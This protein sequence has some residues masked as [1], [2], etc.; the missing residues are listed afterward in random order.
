M[1]DFSLPMLERLL[2][3]FK[4]N[5]YQIMR[6]D[7][8]WKNKDYYNSFDRMVLLRHDVDRFPKMAVT[9]AEMEAGNGIFGTFFFRVKP[10]VFKENIIKRIVSLGHEIGYHYEVMTDANGSL[11]E[12]DCLFKENLKRLRDIFPIVSAS[13][14]SRP[15]S[16]FD[17][18]SFWDHVSLEKYGLLGETYRNIDHYKFMYLAD[19]GRNW[20]SDRNVVW[21]YVKGS[22]LSR[23][24]GTPQLCKMIES[25]EINKIHLLIHPNRWR[26]TIVGWHMEYMTDILINTTKSIIKKF[27][28]RELSNG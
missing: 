4:N 24:S 21:D 15:L 14:H 28:T 5:G 25:Q 12:A 22:A 26:S 11:R 9:V 8:Y 2:L 20:S 3:T 10:R 18:R 13:M 19:S 17:N 6:F 27:R 1:L 23:I 16:R 7:Q